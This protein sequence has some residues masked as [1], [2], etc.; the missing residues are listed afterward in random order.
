MAGALDVVVRFLADAS[1]VKDEVDKVDDTGSKIKS[2][3][4]GAALAI[5]GAFAVDKVVEFGK[6]SLDAAAEDAEAQAMLATTMKDVQGATDAQ[7]ASVEKWITKA[8]K[9]Y[10]IADDQLRPAFATLERATKDASSA[11]E[12]MQIAM[13]ASA[14]T[15]KDLA[16]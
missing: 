14:G 6:A 4:K 5:G 16:S 2:W 3:A 1:Q 10:A 9:Q 11:Q 15:G 13:D 8:S 7:V 12:L